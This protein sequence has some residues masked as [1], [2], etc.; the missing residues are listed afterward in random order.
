MNKCGFEYNITRNFTDE[1]PF[2]LMSDYYFSEWYHILENKVYTPKSFVFTYDDLFNG[3]IDELIKTLPN[4]ECFARLDTLSTKPKTSYKNATE[5]INDFISSNRTSEYFTKN[6]NIIIRE[7][8]NLNNIEFRCFVHNKKLRAISSE[9]N[10]KNIDEIKSLVDKITFYT[11]YDSYCLDLTY[12]N[13]KLMV[14]EVNTPVWLF[15]TSGLFCLDEPCD[16]HM[17]VGDYIP[18]V[19]SYPVIK[20]NNTNE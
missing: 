17:L 6:M 20:I 9:G 12:H 7:Y 2:E 18:D 19:I 14:I 8:I 1:D 10:L 11:D 15:A 5:I 13:D 16:L 4:C 3:K